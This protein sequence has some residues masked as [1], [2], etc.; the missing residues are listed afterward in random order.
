MRVLE[1]LWSHVDAVTVRQVRQAIPHLAYT[2]VMTT[3]DRLFRKG[4]LLRHRLG[5]AFA[6]QPRSSRD[7]MVQQLL[8]SHVDELLTAADDG[9]AILS[10]L[11]SA[12]SRRD[13]ALLDELGAL[14]EAERARLALEPK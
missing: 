12:V 11:I 14:V 13:S 1:L 10:T 9:T 3:L 6:Y 7:V 8:S 5:R 2:T 4:L